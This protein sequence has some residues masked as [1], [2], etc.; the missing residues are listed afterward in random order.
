MKRILFSLLAIPVALCAQ[1]TINGGRIIKGIWDASGS[2][3]SLP[4]RTGTRSPVGRDSCTTPG[5][6]YFQSDATPGQNLWV[7][8]GSG[9][10]GAW[11]QISAGTGAAPVSSTVPF[12][13]T[14]VFTVTGPIQEFTLTLTGNV[15]SSTLSGAIA[16]GIVIFD[17]CQDATGNRTFVWPAGFSAAPA[18]S[19]VAGS[20]TTQAFIW[21]GSTAN[22]IAPANNTPYLV[23]S[24]PEL[25]APAT[26][27]GAGLA[28]LW[29]DSIRHT[30]TAAENN[31]ANAH[32][33]PRT[34]GSN[35]QLASTDL[36]DSASLARMNA[37]N[38]FTAGT[39]DFRAAAHTLP[40]VTGVTAARPT[41]CTIGE[42]YFGTDATAG[43]NWFY[44]TAANTWTQQVNTGN[45]T[46]VFGRTGAV[47]A[48]S[49]DYTAA[50]VTNAVATNASNVD[51]AG[52]QDF[53]AAAHTLPA[54]T[55]LT[56]ARPSTCTVGEMYFA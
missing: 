20:C 55:G 4:N 34:A 27:P 28:S 39:Q 56:S 41:T 19:S 42:M 12:N 7:C 8:T 16:N 1:T 37:S 23:S 21:T 24:V 29:A 51:T 13:A 46:N 48:Q 25:A 40:A 53:R 33:M 30:F 54:V 11:S 50:Q 18:I 52:T 26:P 36:A 44:C 5:E 35:D 43:Q 38:T 47:T 22:P 45:I 2:I 6:T 31:S 17:V 49:G 14:P 32:I 3:R 9:T 15:T 10:P